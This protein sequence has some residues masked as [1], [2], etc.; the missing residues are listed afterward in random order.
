MLAKLVELF[1]EETG[2]DLVEYGLLAALV[3]LASIVVWHA[4]S[5]AI[6][7]AYGGYDSG[8]QDLW[9]PPDP[10]PPVPPGP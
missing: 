1:R 7:G 10:P 6:A 2:Q 9:E 8:V 4:I 3:V 5:D